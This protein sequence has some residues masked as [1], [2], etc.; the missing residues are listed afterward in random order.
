MVSAMYLNL[1]EQRDEMQKKLGLSAIIAKAFV[2]PVKASHEPK[3]EKYSLDFLSK[4]LKSVLK[5]IST[6]FSGFAGNHLG[7]E[8]LLNIA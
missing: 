6:L 8:V 2:I 7:S 5:V 3:T 1:S 4:Q